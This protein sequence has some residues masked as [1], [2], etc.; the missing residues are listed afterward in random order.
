[1][2]LNPLPYIDFHPSLT[3]RFEGLGQAIPLVLPD[4]VQAYRVQTAGS[5]DAL[6]PADSGIFDNNFTLH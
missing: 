1:M 4:V 3:R 2:V 5:T 6:A